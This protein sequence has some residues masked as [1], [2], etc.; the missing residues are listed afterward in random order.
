MVQIFIP[1]EV[2]DTSHEPLTFLMLG[3]CV[4]HYSRRYPNNYL[5]CVLRPSIHT[6][7]TQ[8]V[9]GAVSLYFCPFVFMLAINQV[10]TPFYYV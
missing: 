10:F 8:S 7:T 3:K 5:N 1:F 6:D 2:H 4:N 9:E